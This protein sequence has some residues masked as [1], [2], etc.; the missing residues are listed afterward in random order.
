MFKKI[1]LTIF[2]EKNIFFIFLREHLYI[3][4][5]YLV[6]Q[7]NFGGIVMAAKK[8]HAKRKPAHKGKAKRRR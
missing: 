6:I 2:L 5:H 3:T 7:L 8:K 1:L 4:L